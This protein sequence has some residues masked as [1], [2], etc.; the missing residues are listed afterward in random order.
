MEPFT[1]AC[2]QCG[3]ETMALRRSKRFCSECRAARDDAAKQRFERSEAGKRAHQRWLATERGKEYHREYQRAAYATVAGGDRRRASARRYQSKPAVQVRN[4]EWQRA[5]Y[6]TPEGRARVLAREARR[7][8]VLADNYRVFAL[9][10]ARGEATCYACDAPAA[11]VDHVLPI[12]MARLVGCIE[13]VDMY[14]API[15]VSC[16]VCKSALD[17]R[18]LRRMR[19]QMLTHPES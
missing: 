3:R 9:A 4:R 13:V 16:H 19:R 12:S 11:Q 1:V 14:V 7:R 15:C 10:I 5:N 6:A 2:V 8:G 18:D 17:I